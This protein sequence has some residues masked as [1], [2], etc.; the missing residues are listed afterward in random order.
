MSNKNVIPVKYFYYGMLTIALTIGGVFFFLWFKESK[1]E[2]MLAENGYTTKATIV[3]LYETKSSKRSHP[4]YYMEVA[5]FT[6]S[7]AKTAP[8]NNTK[9]NPNSTKSDQVV[10]VLA[11]QTASL[12]E[13]LGIY[14]TKTIPLTSYNQ[15]K[16]YKIEDTVLV[17]YLKDNPSVIRLKS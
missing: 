17:V 14:Q 1:E 2:E 15:Y 6:D 5:F 10:A 7:L 9:S 8:E 13:P 16:K 4:N 3:D 12:R 11:K